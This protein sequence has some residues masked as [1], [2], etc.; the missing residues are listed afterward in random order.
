MHVYVS[1]DLPKIYKQ[2]LQLDTKSINSLTERPYMKM[3]KIFQRKIN[4]RP[5]TTEKCKIKQ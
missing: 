4:K 5:K 1:Q 3:E 2:L